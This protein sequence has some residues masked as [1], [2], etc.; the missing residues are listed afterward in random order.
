MKTITAKLTRCRHGRPL[1][2]LDSEPF[3]GMEIRP[4]DLLAMAQTLIRIADASVEHD[5][6][7]RYVGDKRISLEIENV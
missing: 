6:A 5:L 1:V 3:N 7:T 4:A 2:V